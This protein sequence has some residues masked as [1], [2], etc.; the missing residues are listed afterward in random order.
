MVNKKEILNLYKNMGET[1]LECLERF[2]VENP[3]WQGVP[4]TYAGRLDPMAKGLLLV[5]A[6]D[7]DETE[8]KKLLLLDKTY[9]FEVLW[10]IKTDTYDIL[11]L[12]TVGGGIPSVE[13][14][15][16][17]TNKLVGKRSQKYP[18]YSSK[19][20]KGRP[21]FSFARAGNI[22]EIDIPQ[23]EIAVFSA[24]ILSQRKI[25]GKE[26][27]AE[28]ISGVSRVK[29]DF[30]QEEIIGKWKEVLSNKLDSE[31]LI[32]KMC[33]E[34]SSG[35]YIRSIANELGEKLGCGAC[36]YSIKRTQIG[37]YSI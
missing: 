34:V 8:K 2:K 4:M 13:S 9:E 27:L 29:G 5:L 30:R 1:P 11:G 22:D 36:A 16:S 25:T 15:E 31:F 6:G 23:K 19:P 21:L 14:I 32:T 18:P 10:G 20:V 37:G 28:I 26:L 33:A 24:G 35:T 17:E 7:I 3:K 12:P